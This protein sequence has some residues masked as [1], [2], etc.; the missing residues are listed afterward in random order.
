MIDGKEE[1]LAL[2]VKLGSQPICSFQLLMEN[3]MLGHRQAISALYVLYVYQT[4]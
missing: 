1:T 3:G 4:V 2:C